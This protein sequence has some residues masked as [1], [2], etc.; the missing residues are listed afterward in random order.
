MPTLKNSYPYYL[1][2]EAVF[3]N[4]D[5]VVTDKYSGE[6]ATRV[7]LADEKAIDAGI[8]AAVEAQPAMAAMAAY[9][10]QAVLD[11]AGWDNALDVRP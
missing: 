1:A 11:Q 9:E 2:S 10:R 7:A 6:E 5:L 4:E 8:Q 3:A